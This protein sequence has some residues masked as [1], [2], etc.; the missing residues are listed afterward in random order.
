MKNLMFTI[1]MAVCMAVSA[2]AFAG[3]TAVTLAY[4]GASRSSILHV[5]STYDSRNA[6]PLV[7][8]F[9]GSGGSGA[10]MEQIT[11]F[12]AL[13]DQ[14]GFFVAYP[15]S[16]GA[17]WVLTGTNNDVGFTQALVQTIQA[18]YHLDPTRVYA[19]GYS[20]GG[21]LVH[22]LG[23]CAGS[24]VAGLGNV[25]ALLWPGTQGGCTDDPP[26]T[27]LEFHGTADPVI[28]YGGYPNANGAMSDSSL[29]T[30]QTWA[31]LDGCANPSSPASIS[32]VDTL[33]SGANVTDTA[34]R[35]TACKNGTTVSFY[36]IAGGGHTWPGGT[37]PNLPTLGP[38]SQ[39]VNASLLMWQAFST[40]RSPTKYAGVCGAA[41]NVAVSTAPS[42][43]LCRIGVAGSVGGVGPWS[44]T[45]PGYNGGAAANCSAPKR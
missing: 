24:T 28:P 12:D 26:N 25:S 37:Q 16:A 22:Q 31:Q 17:T 19:S 36:T 1:V 41:N 39:K 45:C 29:Q 10:K 38:V 43:G 13:A 3:S 27:Y 44:W 7:L 33:N 9:H 5:P 21:G 42:T 30:A 20:Q 4:G 14:Y 6:Y 18:S 23:Y 34:L 11:G 2:R 8:V 40:S 15:D 35:W 32:I